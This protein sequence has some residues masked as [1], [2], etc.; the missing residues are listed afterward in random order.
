MRP[1]VLGAVLLLL[2]GCV[3]FERHPYPQAPPPTSPAQ[4]ILSEDEAVD[5]GYRLCADRG[6]RVNRVERARL[7]SSGRWHVTL[8]GIGDRAQ[9]MLD[10]RDGKLL[11]GRFHR[12]ESEPPGVGQQQGPAPT[13][14]ASPPPPPAPS[15]P[16]EDDEAE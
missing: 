7:D 16:S 2:S 1:F 12:E 4:R 6:L 8:A 14:P 10:G 3:V 13:R 11:K 5:V 9:M 15:P